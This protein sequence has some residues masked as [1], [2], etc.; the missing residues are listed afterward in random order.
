MTID[1]ASYPTVTKM[2]FTMTGQ[3]GTASDDGVLFDDAGIYVECGTAQSNWRVQPVGAAILSQMDWNYQGPQ[4]P[5]TGE[6]MVH[7]KATGIAV[8]ATDY[9]DLYYLPDKS[10]EVHPS[11]H[12]TFIVWWHVAGSGAITDTALALRALVLKS[13]LSISST[14]LQTSIVG[15][16]SSF[17]YSPTTNSAMAYYS[18]ITDSDASKLQLFI[19]IQTNRHIYIDDVMLVQGEVPDEVRDSRGFWPSDKYERYIKV[20]D[21]LLVAPYILDANVATSITTYGEHENE[22]NNSLVTDLATALTYAAGTFNSK[23]TPKIA[24]KL[25][26]FAARK[27]IGQAGKVKLV[28]IPN[29]PAAL[30]PARASYT[31]SADS[32]NASVELGNQRPDLANLL[33]LTTERSR[34]G[35]V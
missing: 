11:E 33:L 31:I 18:I 22:G 4:T 1:T 7:V 29:A 25:E 15:N 26:I 10:P 13:D 2:R 6:Y 27:I 34:R 19:R 3:G 21:A 20:T 17:T 12:Y 28:N 9:I 8:P 23:A 24:A 32:I 35:L 30:W 5:R 14:H 16:P